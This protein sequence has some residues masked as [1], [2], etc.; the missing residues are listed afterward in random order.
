MTNNSVLLGSCCPGPDTVNR[1]VIWNGSSTVIPS[2]GKST[3]TR[4][5][6]TLG[7]TGNG[8]ADI[9]GDIGTVPVRLTLGANGTGD[10]T[11][12]DTGGVCGRYE[13]CGERD[14][15]GVLPPP[16]DALFCMCNGR[17]DAGA[18]G[19]INGIRRDS[20]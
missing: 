12:P 10:C 13:G 19:A 18:A 7:T 15:G 2:R 17:A 16:I 8:V 20:I 11:L 3:T 4:S 14:L 1:Q 6:D 5:T 9:G